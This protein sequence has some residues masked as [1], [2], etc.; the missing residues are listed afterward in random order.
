MR[1]DK[2]IWAVRMVKTRTAASSACKLGHVLLN[3]IIA[4]PAKEIKVGDTIE[5]ESKNSRKIYRVE[6][7]IAK[8][9]KPERVA[10]YFTDI[11]P[12]EVIE[13][14]EQSIQLDQTRVI[15][16]RYNKDQGRP[17]KRDRRQLDQ[18]KNDWE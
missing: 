1:I 10:Q 2:W 4:K 5:V 3:G 16:P 13:E 8:P 15:N 7:F 6:G 18:F 17:T 11:T 14:A 12:A 9:S